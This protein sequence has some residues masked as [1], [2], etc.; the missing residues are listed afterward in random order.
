M[1]RHLNKV[2]YVYM[3]YTDSSIAIEHMVN[4]VII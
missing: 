1:L 4:V 3:L 2:M